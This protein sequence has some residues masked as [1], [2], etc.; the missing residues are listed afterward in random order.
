MN[1]Y[2]KT[3]GLINLRQC[4]KIIRNRIHCA[5]MFSNRY[6]CVLS[7]YRII[8]QSHLKMLFVI[9]FASSLTLNG[10]KNIISVITF[11]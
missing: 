1:F 9:F 3:N 5:I 10:V 11:A 6:L 4:Q 2:V 8:F 7:L